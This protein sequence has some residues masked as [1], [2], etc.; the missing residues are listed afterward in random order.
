MWNE[1]GTK[2]VELPD[3]N[4]KIKLNIWDTCGEE[5]F[6]NLLSRYLKDTDLVI[7]WFDITDR[8]GFKNLTEWIELINNHL[9][10]DEII[11]FLCGWKCDL[12]ELRDVSKFEANK[13]ALDNSLFYFETSAKE[14]IS[15]TSMFENASYKLYLK[16][17]RTK[18][19]TITLNS[20][21]QW[22]SISSK[23]WDWISYL[24]GC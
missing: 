2:W 15:I 19:K 14:N 17:V 18:R 22:K 5:K 11:I 21:T 24:F 1:F 3:F 6:K 7:L 8:D 4:S 23:F 13:F 20:S 12:E 9:N 10:R 16:P